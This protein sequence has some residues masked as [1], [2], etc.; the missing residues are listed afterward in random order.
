MKTCDLISVARFHLSK[1][2]VSRTL[3]APEAQRLIL[4][5]LEAADARGFSEPGERSEIRLFGK[6]V[7]QDLDNDLLTGCSDNFVIWCLKW[8]GVNGKYRSIGGIHPTGRED[9]PRRPGRSIDR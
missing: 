1:T 6:R 4:F 8:A 3:P 5:D 2:S 7:S 9:H